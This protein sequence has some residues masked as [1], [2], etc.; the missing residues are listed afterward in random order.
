MIFI[1]FNTPSSK[2]SKIATKNGVFHSKTVKK[3][4]TDL[5]IMGFNPAKREVKF[6]KK[7]SCLFPTMDLKEM[8]SYAKQDEP[9]VI[10][11]HFVRGTKH[12]FDFHNMCQIILDLLIAFDVIEDDDMDHVIPMPLK[13]D[14]RWY[15]VDKENP[16]VWVTIMN[17]KKMLPDKFLPKFF[18]VN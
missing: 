12:K 10:G 15:S 16:G 11:F 4:L 14:G 9:I 5:G 18:G 6:Y 3:Y 1:P 7:K 8:F 13:Y 2:N 17:P